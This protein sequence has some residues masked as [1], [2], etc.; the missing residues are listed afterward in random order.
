M[1]VQ[2]NGKYVGNGYEQSE[3]TNP[4]T[5]EII[6]TIPKLK[7][8][9]VDEAVVAAKE[10][11]K[12]WG[13]MSQGER[14]VILEK[15]IA[16]YQENRDDLAETLTRETGK[17]YAQAQAEMDSCINLT[18]AYS[19]KA[20]HMYGE[21]LSTGSTLGNSMQDI[22]FTR[23]EPLGI[24]ACLLPFNFP[25][26]LLGNKVI[27]AIVA[28]NAVIIKPPSDNPLTIIKTVELLHKAGVPKK[29]A[30][31]VTGSGAII[32]DYLVS[33]PGIDAMSMTGSTQVGIDIYQKAAKNLIPVY[34]EL[35]GNDALVV[36]EDSDIDL[37]VEESVMSRILNSGQVC[38]ASKR[39]IVHEDIYDE[40]VEKLIGRL[41]KIT[42]GDPLDPAMD[43]GCLINI[44][45]AIEVEEQVE[46]TI[47]QGAKCVLGGK[48]TE[49][50][51]FP[52]TVLINVSKDS[53]ICKDLEVFGPVFPIIPFKTD[54]EALE[55]SNS[56]C[57]GLSGAVFSKNVGRAISIA[58][59]METAS[60]VINGG[61]CYRPTE[62]AFG[63]YKKSGLGREGVSHTL[64]EM[65]Q[66][67][68]YTL[69][70]V[71]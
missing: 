24:I 50:A 57:Y 13:Y 42:M 67:K 48:I 2:I 55:I 1:L 22:T 58:S 35:G 56:S 63:G 14:N 65:T 10:G 21:C 41:E 47:K 12:D 43:M 16:L 32:G 44:R 69:K 20:A 29:A 51:F 66:I 8:K 53:D 26:D 36:L 31:V 39:F 45:A 27:P 68:S 52:P 62:L 11:L 3:I 23:Y 4:A 46:L 38:C 59:K 37:A 34:L 60:I 33:H 28:G 64:S 71:L 61:S 9:D 30:Q 18:R 7:E 49:G 17:V 5:N 15:F 25:I 70:G 6:D 40:Y 54:E 19:E